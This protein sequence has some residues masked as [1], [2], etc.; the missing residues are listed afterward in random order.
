MQNHIPANRQS[1]VKTYPEPNKVQDK[2]GP[3]NTGKY[4]P[5]NRPEPDAPGAGF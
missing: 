4:G 1:Q 2:P 3:Q 5:E